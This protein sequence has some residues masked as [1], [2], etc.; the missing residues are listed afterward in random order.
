MHAAQLP[1][2]QGRVQF[3]QVSFRYRPELPPALDR[4]GIVIPPGRRIAV[5]GESGA[6][7]ELIAR[8]VNMLF[9]IGGDG[10]QRGSNDLYQEARRR[11]HALACSCRCAM[12]R[13]SAAST[14]T[15]A[16]VPIFFHSSGV[17]VA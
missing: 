4:V 14:A 2:L 13:R 1:P 3:D 9:T 8:G 11:G 7:K 12:E 6:G 10:T 17:T 16:S 5:V 15:N